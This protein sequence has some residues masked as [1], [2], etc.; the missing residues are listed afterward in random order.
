MSKIKEIQEPIKGQLKEFEA[1]YQQLLTVDDNPLIDKMIRYIRRT[2]GKK[3]R[4]TLV[5]LASAINGEINR[6][7]LVSALL[8]E[9]THTASLIHD[10]VIDESNYRRGMWSVNA[11]WRSKNAVLIGDYILS[12]GIRTAVREGF[13][14]IIEI[15]SDSMIKMSRGELLQSDSVIEQN[16]SRERYFEVIEGKTGVLLSAC[17]KAGAISSRASQSNVEIMS[18]FG[19]L[20][21]SAFQIKDD[22]LD[23]NAKNSL[24]KPKGNDIR[25]R[26]LTLPL[27]TALE[28]VN[29][30]KKRDILKLLKKADYKE[31]N[32]SKIHQ[33]VIKNGGIELSE[34]IMQQ[35]EEQALELLSNFPDS[36]FKNALIE[37]SK[38][39]LKRNR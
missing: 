22:I 29:D 7:S 26:K 10:D 11:L 23:Y 21:G 9:L 25:E 1:L 16:I 13:Y 31:E 17:A 12:L 18:K 32:V 6:H 2:G 34:A 27:I 3:M 24:G 37:Y 14:D 30:A 8:I 35:Y 36:L 38:Y 33:F 4:P 5:L 19:L 39:I 28:S 15:I 20:L